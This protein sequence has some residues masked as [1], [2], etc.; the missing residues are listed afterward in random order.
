M[1]QP[2][3]NPYEPVAH[4]APVSLPT[5]PLVFDGVI[6]AVDYQEMLPRD[7]EWWLI[8]I[9]AV[10]LGICV[11][12]FGPLSVL[13]AIANAQPVVAASVFGFWTLMLAALWFLKLRI[14]SRDRANRMLRRYPD[15]LG[16]ASG[17]MSDSGLV[18]RDGIHTYWFGPQ[19]MKY[20]AI[21]R[22]GIRM[23]VDGSVYRYLALSARLFEC[24]R[25]ELASELKRRWA[26][27][28]ETQVAE[29]A[30]EDLEQWN[31]VG[32][33][34]VDA[35]RFKGQVTVEITLRTVALR[36]K[37]AFE[38]L[39]FLSIPVIAALFR[40]H[41]ESWVLWTGMLC[42]IYGL[43]TNLRLWLTYYRGTAQHSWY[44]FGWIS[45]KEFATYNNSAAVRMPLTDIASK[46]ESHDLIVLTLKSGQPY[47]LPRHL[48]ASEE[49]WNRLRAIPAGIQ[50]SECS[51]KAKSD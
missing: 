45:E 22:S 5:E 25:V 36:N 48:V 26:A 9:L 8:V 10:L 3:I 14:S 46:T 44:Q 51:E 33:P 17:V 41:V 38:L 21:L 47:H 28:A 12:V 32:E 23:S 29:D 1:T 24:Y 35:I 37:A 15:V 6:E 40:A 34:P 31:R 50:D 11:L 27:L 49:Q 2:T 16:S 13:F 18:F 43:I 4:S 19:H 20:A 30:P 42:V 39:A 7:Q